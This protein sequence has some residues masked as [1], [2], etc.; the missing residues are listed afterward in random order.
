MQPKFPPPLQF[1]VPTIEVHLIDCK[2]CVFAAPEM[3]ILRYRDKTFSQ[4]SVEGLF[5]SW[6][7]GTVDHFLDYVMEDKMVTLGGYTFIESYNRIFS[8]TIIPGNM[9]VDL[10]RFVDWHLLM[11]PS[12]TPSSK[13]VGYIPVPGELIL[14][15]VKG[16]YEICGDLKKGCNYI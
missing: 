16:T 6:E 12:I 10:V 13:P 2:E 5:D 3:M 8:Y 11:T 14:N 15:L 4:S 1:Y 9:D 7:G